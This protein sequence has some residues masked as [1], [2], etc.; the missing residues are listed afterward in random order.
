MARGYL[1]VVCIV[2]GIVGVVGAVVG[3]AAL[4]YRGLEPRSALSLLEK[5][6]LVQVGDLVAFGIVPNAGPHT[7]TYK[8]KRNLDGSVELEYTYGSALDGARFVLHSEAEVSAS[9]KNAGGSFRARV[10]AYQIGVRLSAKEGTRLLDQPAL[11]GVGAANYVGQLCVGGKPA[12]ST[13]VVWQGKTV[14]SVQLSGVF[15]DDAEDW[16]ALLVPRLAN[17]GAVSCK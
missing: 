16:K 15:I 6:L 2:A 11:P 14:F 3:V 4:S 7:E 12:G 9:E 10:K 13:V 17:E 1:I 8:A 5:S